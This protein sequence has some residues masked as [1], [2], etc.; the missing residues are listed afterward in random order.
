MDLA[1]TLA[2][3]MIVVIIATLWVMLRPGAKS[4]GITHPGND[5]TCKKMCTTPGKCMKQRSN[6]TASSLTR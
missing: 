3:G 1:N 6:V 2:F 5:C 4:R